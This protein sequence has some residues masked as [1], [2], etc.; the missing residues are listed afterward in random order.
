M[1]SELKRKILCFILVPMS[2][3]LDQYAKHAVKGFMEARSRANFDLIPGF[4]DVVYSHN[5]G[6]AF[7]MMQGIRPYILI[8][9]VVVIVAVLIMVV[10]ME[11]S[12]ILSIGGLSLMLGGAL[13][14]L[15][16]RIRIGSVFDFIYF[17][18]GSFEW[19]VF[20]GADIFIVIGTALFAIAMLRGEANA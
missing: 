8:F 16:D 15:V 4:L 14:N 10:R 7:G 12:G 9:A 2:V 6:V 13:G 1:T 18:A 20:N 3:I 17:H 19:P 5:T 11:K